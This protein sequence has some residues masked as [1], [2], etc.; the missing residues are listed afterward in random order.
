MTASHPVRDELPESACLLDDRAIQSLLALAQINSFCDEFSFYYKTLLEAGWARER[1]AIQ[2]CGAK[3]GFP[4]AG[5]A[6]VTNDPPLAEIRDR[7]GCRSGRKEAEAS[8]KVRSKAL[9][10]LFIS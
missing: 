7:P 8:M 2:I 9:S 1:T 6:R 5:Y 10:D 4:L 3:V